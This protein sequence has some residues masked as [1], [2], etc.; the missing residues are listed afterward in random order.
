MCT[1]GRSRPALPAGGPL[2]AVKSNDAA[3]VAVAQGIPTAAAASYGLV[4]G[5]VP[6]LGSG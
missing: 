5:N 1:S 4:K 2:P 6:S 3:A